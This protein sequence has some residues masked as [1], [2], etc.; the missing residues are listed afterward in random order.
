MIKISNF[1]KLFLSFMLMINLNTAQAYTASVGDTNYNFSTFTGTWS[2]YTSEYGNPAWWGSETLALSFAD[3]LG[4]AFGLPNFSEL[5]PL[6][7]YAAASNLSF[8]QYASYAPPAQSFNFLS[9]SG[10][11][12]F[13]VATEVAPTP[14]PE[15]DG[16]VLPQAF[17]LMGALGYMF[18]RR[19][20]SW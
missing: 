20:V 4:G 13:A 18:S 8:A 3:A 12:T 15:I 1:T 2:G 5:G 14:V 11:Y 9:A 6:F 10:E 7:V 16:S 19:R 17:L